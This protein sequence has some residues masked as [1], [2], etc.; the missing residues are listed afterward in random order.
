M[1]GTDR[2][3]I[4]TPCL[5]PAGP[6]GKGYGS[7]PS[8]SRRALVCRQ[9]RLQ[10]PW[11]PGPVR[12]WVSPLHA[13]EPPVEERS[14][15]SGVRTPPKHRLQEEAVFGGSPIGKAHPAGTGAKRSR[16]PGVGASRGSRPSEM[17]PG[18]V[19]AQNVGHACVPWPGPAA[20]KGCQLPRR[21][22]GKYAD[23]SRA[24][25][26]WRRI[27]AGGPSAQTSSRPLG[28]G[29]CNGHPPERRR[30]PGPATHRGRRILLT[31]CQA[32]RD[33]ARLARARSHLR[34]VALV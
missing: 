13:D 23:K 5:I 10:V 33:L 6:P 28:I 17:P 9:A 29:P 19:E 16:P 4:R 12:S 26:H 27:R 20:S 25:W 1:Y 24:I 3:S 34:Q 18:A 31:R 14:P 30:T 2:S 32:R 21:L 8:G 11:I 7:N 15:L 22:G